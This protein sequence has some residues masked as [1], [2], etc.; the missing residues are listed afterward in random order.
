MNTED[1]LEYLE[2]KFM[3]LNQAYCDLHESVSK[4]TNAVQD[5]FMDISEA[6]QGIVKP[7]VGE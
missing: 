2:N 1:R 6:V 3:I 4:L 5:S 7:K